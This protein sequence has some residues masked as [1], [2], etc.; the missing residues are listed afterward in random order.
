MTRSNRF[1]SVYFPEKR[2]VWRRST[3]NVMHR[4]WK[5]TDRPKNCDFHLKKAIVPIK[6]HR[7]ESTMFAMM[8]CL[9]PCRTLVKP[10]CIRRPPLTERSKSVLR[11]SGSCNMTY[12]FEFSWNES[13]V[14]A[15]SFASSVVPHTI[16]LSSKE[17]TILLIGWTIE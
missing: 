15:H 17:S 14:F 3:L 8:Y 13:D 10:A 2:E 12:N 9:A 16:A 5:S 4:K 6:K 7:I 11:D 1:D